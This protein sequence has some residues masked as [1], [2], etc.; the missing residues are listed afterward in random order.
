MRYRLQMTQEKP[1]RQFINNLSHAMSAGETLTGLRKEYLQ[2][3]CNVP[4]VV[5]RQR[6]EV[7]QAK[8]RAQAQPDG[9]TKKWLSIQTAIYEVI[10]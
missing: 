4:A 3:F 7:D 10:R 6:R 9:S 1:C 2:A 8:R 5:E